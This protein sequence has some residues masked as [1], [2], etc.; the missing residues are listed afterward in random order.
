M[1]IVHIT[2]DTDMLCS[3]VDVPELSNCSLVVRQ[4]LIYFMNQLA[5]DCMSLTETCTTGWGFF[6]RFQRN[7]RL[8]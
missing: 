5:D 2:D 6:A 8:P 4:L 7:S 3:D 1:S